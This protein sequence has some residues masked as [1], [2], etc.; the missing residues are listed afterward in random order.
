VE[1]TRLRKNSDFTRLYRRGRV[2][3]AGTLLIRTAPNHLEVTRLAVVVSKKVS[4]SAARRNRLRRQVR[5]AWRAL[6]P[7]QVQGL[8]VIVTVTADKEHTPAEIAAALRRAE[9]LQ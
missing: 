9:L 5:E 1:A 8:D 6:S 2:T 4:K 7:S 3:R